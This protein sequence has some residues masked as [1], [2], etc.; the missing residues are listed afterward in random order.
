MIRWLWR[1]IA[2]T[3]SGDG[4]PQ[5]AANLLVQARL[6]NTA[7]DLREAL[8]EPAGQPDFMSQQLPKLLEGLRALR[9]PELEVEKLLTYADFY[10]G[11]NARA[12]QRVVQQSLARDDYTLFMTACAYCYLADRF[13]EGAVLLDMFQPD[14]DPS[15]DWAE[16]LAYAAY[17]YFAA[18]RPIEQSLVCIDRAVQGFNYFSPL[19][20]VNAYAIYFEAG[21][22]A[23]CDALNAWMHNNCP[24]DPGAVYAKAC[25]ELARGYYPEGFRLM[26]ARYRMPQLDRF[27]NA[28]LL[29]KPRWEQQSLH[30]KRLLVHGEQGL[31]DLIMMA[32]YLPLLR[33][34][35]AQLVLDM[36]A[37]AVSL[38][39]HNFPWC[40]FIVG[41]LKNPIT[42]PF[43]YWTGIMS[44]PHHFQSTTE[45][46]PSK[47]GYLSA[48]EEQSAYWKS[49]I[50]ALPGSSGLRVGIAWSGNP[51]HR[52]DKR[53][54]MPF[55]LM[56][57]LVR[58]HPD[59][60]FFPL[61]TQ[62]PPGRPSNMVDLADELL[63]MA[64]TAAVISGM[65]LVISVDTS[66]IHV[67]GALGRTAWLLLP[68]R[69]EWRWGLEGNSN[70]WYDSVRVLRQ[71][72][73]GAWPELLDRVDLALQDLKN[74][75][76]VAR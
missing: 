28:S 61:Q 32:R 35:G 72:Q 12:Y 31:G 44:L 56:S 70:A 36:R 24:D 46:L 55:A 11:A 65:D 49:R 23:E 71:R 7:K 76:A 21:R 68:Y 67:A 63:T 3:G 6:S 2:S 14:A 18:G 41:D 42:E 62:A 10:S 29:Q 17:I 43:D 58:K 64:D 15:T 34:Q 1:R 39:Q 13:E 16:Y 5:T 33:E 25:I 69:Y 54:S 53:R 66:A 59:I 48:P 26:E 38:F 57:D 50:H 20:V 22:L 37:E 8:R 47:E 52:A 9:W 19:L 40:T 75:K 60:Q 45:N 51:G 74:T 73:A 4:G 27:I 30:G